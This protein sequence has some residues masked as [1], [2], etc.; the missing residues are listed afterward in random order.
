[1]KLSSQDRDIKEATDLIVIRDEC[2]SSCEN[3]VFMF[4]NKM[5]NARM[6]AF[7]WLPAVPASVLT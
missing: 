1:M 3:Y 6:W 5:E 2:I 7:V 4:F